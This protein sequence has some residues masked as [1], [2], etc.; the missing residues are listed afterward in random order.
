[1]A[2]ESS[3]PR[4]AARTQRFRLGRPRSVSVSP[5]GT[6]VLFLRSGSGTDPVN[7]LWQ[8]DAETGGERLVADAGALLTG[9]A[10]FLSPLE[11][12]R[13]E[14]AR[15]SSAGIVAYAVDRDMR[16]CVFALSGRLFWVD[17]IADGDGGVVREVPAAG[18]IVDPRPSPDGERIAYVAGGALHVTDAAGNDL[19]VASEGGVSWGVAEFVA[20]EEMGR[21]RGYWW[22][23]DGAH[24]LAARVDDLH[25]QRWYIADP[26]EPDRS[27]IEV[28]YPR[29]GTPNVDLRLAVLDLD[30]GRAE[31]AWDREHFPYLIAAHWSEAGPPLIS[32]MTRDQR[33]LQLLSLD[34]DTGATTVVRE[35]TDDRWVTVVPGIPLWAPGGR[36]VWSVDR[37]GARRLMVDGQVVTPPSLHVRGVLDVTERGVVVSASESDPAHTVAYL[38]T[39]EREI[40]ALTDDGL[41][42]VALGGPDTV[43]RMHAGMDHFG[44]TFS[45]HRGQSCHPITSYEQTPPLTPMVKLLWAGERRLRTGVLLPTG[46]VPGTRLPVLLDPYGGPEHQEVVAA[47]NAWVEAQWLADQGF[48]VVVADGRGSPGRG[49]EW[50]RAIVGDLGTAPLEDQIDALNA[51]ATDNPDLDLSRVA[52]RG[53]SF[54]GYLAAAALLRRPDVFRAAIAGAPVADW[55]MYDTFYTERYL[56]LDAAGEAYR[57]SSL[58]DDAAGAGDIGELLILHGLADDNVVIAHSLLLSSALFAAGKLHTLLPLPGVTHMTPQEHIAE[59]LLL[60]QVDFLRRALG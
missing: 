53:W 13:R 10:E 24:L 17:L 25:V 57:R 55:T 36:L 42:S 45:V 11:R 12:A 50:E 33:T 9:D 6:R 35:E 43:V 26:A 47:R 30:G 18:Q 46:H 28:A 16:I 51:A 14:R 8:F 5:D 40:T 39:W 7:N 34:P 31:V 27:P 1:M 37:D 48:A 21:T 58:L 2:A 32:V 52:I 41:S 59:N 44:T 60:L 19:G 15:E 49:V 4:L 56:G 22:S 20:A 29:A 54:G 3:Y 38:V 23:P